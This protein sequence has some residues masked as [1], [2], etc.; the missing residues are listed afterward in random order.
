MKLSGQE[1]P[2]EYFFPK[3]VAVKK[4]FSYQSKKVTAS[5]GSLLH[6]ADTY[7]WLM[8]QNIHG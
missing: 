5:A 6:A 7:G 8:K 4:S 2:P 1:K 3:T